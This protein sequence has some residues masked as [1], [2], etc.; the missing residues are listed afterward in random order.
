MP[1]FRWR[2]CRQRT[3][4][5]SISRQVCRSHMISTFQETRTFVLGQAIEFSADPHE[6]DRIAPIVIDD[7]ELLRFVMLDSHLLLS[8]TLYG[9]SNEKLMRIKDNQLVYSVSPWDI[10]LIGSN[11]LIRQAS[12]EVLLDLLFE[13]PSRVTVRRAQFLR[14]GVEVLIRPRYVLLVN[15]NNVFSGFT[16]INARS[17]IVIG[18]WHRPELSPCAMR[19]EEEVPRDISEQERADVIRRAEIRTR[20]VDPTRHV[21]G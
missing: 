15:T 8:M 19:I 16:V 13:P 4:G 14:N 9:P 3:D 21:S 6:V 17:G 20:E 10:E 18:P 1:Y 12:R 2:M 11:L 5:R 7:E